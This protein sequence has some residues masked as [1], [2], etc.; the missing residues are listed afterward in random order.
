MTFV[1][2][3]IPARG[4]RLLL[5]TYATDACHSGRSSVV[6]GGLEGR[7]CRAHERQVMYVFVHARVRGTGTDLAHTGQKDSA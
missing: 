6:Q 2:E 3:S 5:Q 1:R 4:W 7:E